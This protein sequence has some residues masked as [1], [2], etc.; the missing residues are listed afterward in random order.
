[1]SS[2]CATKYC[3]AQIIPGKINCALCTTI[4]YNETLNEFIAC[5]NSFNVKLMI[6]ARYNCMSGQ[7]K[8]YHL[9]Q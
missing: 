9:A 5:K 1:M 7:Y 2:Q 8:L 4:Q 6:I 3:Y